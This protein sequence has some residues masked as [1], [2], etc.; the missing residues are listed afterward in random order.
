M[1]AWL[2]KILKNTFINSFKKEAKT[3]EHV[4]FDRLR[5]LEDELASSYDPEE[6]LLFRL[7]GDEF[8]HAVE[9]LP[10]EFR[11]V[12][13]L[14][15]VQGFSY[16]EIA[17][18]VDIPIGTVMSRLH[19]GRKILRGSLREYAQELGYASSG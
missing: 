16:K 18:I 1:K 17:A 10:E 19:R 2:L 12:V 9:A 11:H 3:P 14:S 8:A 6:E 13:L 7:F 5:L 4:D 15:D